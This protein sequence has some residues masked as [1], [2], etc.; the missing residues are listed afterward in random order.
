VRK[1]LDVALQIFEKAFEL[2]LHRIH[3]L[4]H[5]EDDFHAGKID[6]EIARQRENYFE[7]LKISIGVEPGVA[8]RPR[9]LEKAFAFVQA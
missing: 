4:A 8:L 1:F 2:V 3:F 5:V 6:A 7:P 9:W